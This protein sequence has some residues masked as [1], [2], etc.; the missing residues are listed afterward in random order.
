MSSECVS[1][2]VCTR[3]TKTVLTII[4]F[5]KRRC[6]QMYDFVCVSA[7]EYEMPV[8]S[9][10]KH[11]VA[12]LI[13]ASRT[14]LTLLP[15]SLSLSFLT[16]P[17][18]IIIFPRYITTCVDEYFVTNHNLADCYNLAQ[19]RAVA[20]PISCSEAGTVRLNNRGSLSLHILSKLPH[21]LQAGRRC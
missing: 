3:L 13:P 11:N 17:C 21:E 10:T 12:V 4:Y 5:L 14:P 20:L 8:G 18:T 9:V 1:Y 6:M 7:C 15:L 16:Y 19:R 2:R